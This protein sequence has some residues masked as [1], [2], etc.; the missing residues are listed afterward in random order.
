[1]PEKRVTD[2]TVFGEMQT[3]TTTFIACLTRFRLIA[4]MFS[5]VFTSMATCT[6]LQSDLALAALRYVVYFRSLDYVIRAGSRL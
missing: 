1:M 2:W 4:K 5:S 6:C 3:A